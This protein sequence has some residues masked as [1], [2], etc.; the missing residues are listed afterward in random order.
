[1]KRSA[2][3]DFFRGLLLIVI[4]IDHALTYNN[5]IKRFTY[6]FFGWVSAAEGFVY[7]SGLTAGLVYYHKYVEK[8]EQ[9][10]V[11]AARNRVI[12]LYKYH[13]ALLFFAF[14]IIISNYYITEYWSQYYGYL[15]QKPLLSII[16]SSAL[17]YQPMFMDI[18]PMYTIFVAFIPILVKCFNKGLVWQVLTASI[19]IYIAGALIHP[20]HIIDALVSNKNI[21]TGFYNLLCWQLLF[22]LGAISGFMFYSD[23]TKKIINS[24][25]IFCVCTSVAFVLFIEK[26]L[27]LG[28]SEINIERLTEKSGLGIVRLVN[29]LVLCFMVIYAAARNK[30]WFVNKYIC[31]LGKY[32]LEVF[33]FHI[34]LIITFMPLKVYLNNIYTVKL[35]ENFYLY[36]LSSLFVLFLLVPALYLAP[37]LVNKKIVPIT[38]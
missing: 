14:L 21:Q 31:Y 5:I 37:T 24:R 9:H 4:T 35:T 29:F 1:M 13:V 18:L 22:V 3:L 16:L 11:K 8:G 27:H 20:Y 28:I 38:K 19:A 25:Y 6:E 36:P 7:I 12:T 15:F 17:L 26:N 30:N 32:S 34:V 2:Q 33:S 10:V 23:R